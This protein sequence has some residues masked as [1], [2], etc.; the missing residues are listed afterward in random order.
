MEH[1]NTQ[2]AGVNDASAQRF[3]HIAEQLVKAGSHA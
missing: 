3:A 2:T 1:T